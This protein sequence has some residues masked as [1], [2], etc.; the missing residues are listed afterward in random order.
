MI[1][2]RAR[3]RDLYIVPLW[4][5]TSGSVGL[6]V[7]FNFDDAWDGL[8]R[9]AVFRGSEAENE[10]ALLSDSCMV[11]P[12]VLA[13]PGDD[14][15]IGVYGRDAYGTIAMPTVWGKAGYIYDGTQPI[16]P[17]PSE[18]TPEW[19]YQVQQA[20]AAALRIANAIQTAAENGEFDGEDGYSPT[21]TITTI[22]GGNRVTITDA[23]HPQGQSFDVMDGSGGGG[24]T[25]DYSDLT[26]KPQINGNELRGNKTAAQLGLAASVDI[27]TRTSQ[28][29]NDSGF[30]T[31]HQ[32][33]SGKLNANQ[34]AGNARK[35]MVV[36]S[37]GVVVPVA[38]QAWSGGS[39]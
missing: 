26:N 29:T 7:V 24:G 6:P 27:P 15:Y 38:M 34:G 11:P 32:D 17:D 4:P 39:Y 28:L 21:V 1:A 20:A 25:S 35:F 36:G 14:L 13:T 12:E 23:D 37:D 9:I 2:V 10:V 5:I 33:I 16:E 18:P 30:L 8:N 22:T 31:Q 3:D 19:S